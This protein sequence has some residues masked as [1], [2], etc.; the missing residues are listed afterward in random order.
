MHNMAVDKAD[1]LH[2]TGEKSSTV[3]FGLK[4]YNLSSHP[5]DL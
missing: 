5:N 3:L 1:D 4:R 2:A